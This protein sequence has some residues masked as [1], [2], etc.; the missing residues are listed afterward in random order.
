MEYRLI[1]SLIL[2]SIFGV[3]A[4]KEDI[5]R[6]K[7]SNELNL[8][9]LIIS[10]VIFLSTFKVHSNFDYIYIFIILILSYFLY[11]FELWGGADGKIFISLNLIIVSFFGQE[12]TINYILNIFIF[13]SIIITFLSIFKTSSK[14]K[15][16]VLKKIDYGR[17]SFLLL[18]IFSLIS[19]LNYSFTVE[20]GN[21]IHI[22]IIFSLTL[23]LLKLLTPLIKKTYNKFNFNLKIFFNVIL[24]I[25]LTIISREIFIYY[26]LS[27]IS[28]KIFLEYVS[29]SIS[30]I[31]VDGEKYNSPFSIYLFFSAIFTLIIKT[32]I[33]KILILFF[34]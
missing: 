8:F 3:F 28:F 20:P 21:F 30:M 5:I 9:F 33:L 32:S 25:I 24:F 18:C 12:L 7:V 31:K 14:T 19:I 29:E 6:R 10:V 15:I 1:F 4:I 34:M 2:I 27:I 13:Y 17:N 23:I 16:K 11:H 26:F 22:A